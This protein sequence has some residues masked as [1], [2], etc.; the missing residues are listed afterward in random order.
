MLQGLIQIALTLVIL[1]IIV[2]F[3]GNYMARVFMERCAGQ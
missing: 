1:V 3:F 2:P